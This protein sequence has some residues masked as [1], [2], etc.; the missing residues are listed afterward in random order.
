MSTYAGA[1]WRLAVF[2]VIVADFVKIILVELANETG[3]VA[4]FE[5]FGQNVLG[6]F[7]VL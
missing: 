5:M 4:V 3:E 7:F 2:L 6:E 1:V